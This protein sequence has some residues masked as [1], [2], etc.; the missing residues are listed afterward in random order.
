MTHQVLTL[1]VFTLGSQLQRS[2]DQFGN[3]ASFWFLRFPFKMHFFAYSLA[4]LSEQ[5]AFSYGELAFSG[6][7]LKLAIFTFHILWFPLFPE[8]LNGY[9]SRRAPKSF[10]QSPTTLWLSKLKIPRL[11]DYILYLHIFYLSSGFIIISRFYS[12]HRFCDRVPK[13]SLLSWLRFI[14]M[15]D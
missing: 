1:Q 13:D 2:L 11:Q 7:K 4:P 3:V 10:K 12:W 8:P 5:L 14:M 6:P 9:K 15:F